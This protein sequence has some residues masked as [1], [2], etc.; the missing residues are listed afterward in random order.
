M[1]V[2][3]QILK[4]VAD[5]GPLA[6][7][8]ATQF[9]AVK[10][11]VQGLCKDRSAKDIA[12]MLRSLGATT[13]D[14]IRK[15]VENW[16]AG[17]TQSFSEAESEELIAL[18][19]N[20]TNG[21]RFLT[22]H[23]NVRSS[24]LRSHTMLD[25]LLTSLKPKYQYDDYVATGHD[26]RVK[27]F[28][29]M[30]SFGEVWMA[31]NSGIPELRAYKFFTS[32]NGRNW[33]RR[34]S[35]GLFHIT[36]RLGTHPNIIGYKDVST[37]TTVPFVALEFAGGG[38]LEDW[39]LEDEDQRSDLRVSDAMEGI[40]SAMSAAHGESICHRDLKP[41]NIVLTEHNKHPEVKITDFGLAKDFEQ[42]NASYASSALIVGTP[43]YL[44]PEASVLSGEVDAFKADV[45]AIGMVW[46]Q[47]LTNSLERP[48]Y[49]FEQRLRSDGADTKT[50]STIRRCLASPETRYRNAAELSEDI[51]DLIPK[52][53]IV[54]EGAIDV[55]PVFREY[56][57]SFD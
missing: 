40:I 16:N 37:E 45:F 35:Q 25:K 22:T 12:E 52:R 47:L 50:I 32:E 53:G 46:Y 2:L 55:E 14:Q 57:T 27:R 43:M 48:P 33:L 44:P 8:A 7:W 21:A 24:V 13:D 26:W 1:D 49:D 23:G 4:I 30:G 19:I 54:P 17:L 28:L 29:G 20:L 34:E 42:V 15:L 11:A 38:S 41:S 18:L 6:G 9:P 5:L 39:I 10:K 36:Q 51:S 3:Y 31:Q 56:L